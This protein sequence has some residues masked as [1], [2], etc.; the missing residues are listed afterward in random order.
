MVAIDRSELRMKYE[1]NARWMHAVPAGLYILE[2]TLV[3]LEHEIAIHAAN[4][5][6]DDR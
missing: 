4:I 1:L 2:E 3:P 5:L 6:I